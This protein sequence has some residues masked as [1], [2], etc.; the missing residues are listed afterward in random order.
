MARHTSRS[1]L[2]LLYGFSLLVCLPDSMSTPGSTGT[3]TLLRPGA[4]RDYAVQAG[5]TRVDTLPIEHDLW[6]LY[7]LHP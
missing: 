2:R 4:V 5:Y 1:T 3:G 7:H 6:R